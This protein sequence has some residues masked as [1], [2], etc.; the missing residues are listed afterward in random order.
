MIES[1]LLLDSVTRVVIKR[2]NIDTDRP[3]TLNLLPNEIL[4]P[5]HDG[6][7]G[8]TL[9]EI[10][11]WINPNTLSIDESLRKR[12][13]RN[14]LLEMSDQYMI[15]DFPISESVKDQWRT[16]RQNLRDVPNQVGFPNEVIWPIKPS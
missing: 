11:E 1:V 2:V 10:N 15:S 14:G 13:Q 8:W 7:L 3:E 12:Q 9:N 5:R 16:Y 6:D 4:S